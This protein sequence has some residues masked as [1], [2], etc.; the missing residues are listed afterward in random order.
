LDVTPAAA[1]ALIDKLI[2]GGVVHEATG[3]KRNRVYVA[4]P[5]LKVVDEPL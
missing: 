4:G 1:Q 3:R 5:I 2:E